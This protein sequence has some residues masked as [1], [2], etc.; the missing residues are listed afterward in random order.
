M[1]D[2]A[3]F[4][5]IG[6]TINNGTYRVDQ[7]LASGGF[8]NTYVVTHQHFQKQFVL[9]ELFLK[10]VNERD[11]VDTTVSV[12]NADNKE[13]F[14]QHRRKFLKEA[15]R[16]SDL[17]N[18]HI[19][20]VHDLFE[21]N[22]TAYYVMD[23]IKGQS[24]RDM[25]ARQ[26]GGLGNEQAWD[27]LM[28]MLEA[29]DEVHAK[30]IQHLDIK[31]GNIMC[32]DNGC[33][34]LIDFG[35]SKVIQDDGSM[36]TTS[37]ATA[38]TPG[39][40]PIEQVTQ[41][42]DSYGPWTDFYAL[43]ATLYHVLTGNKPPVS[44]EIVEQKLQAFHFSADADPRLCQL[45]VWMMQLSRTD[46]PQS[47]A[48]IRQWLNGGSQ[49]STKQVP[50]HEQ[51]LIQR[52]QAQNTPASVVSVAN[53]SHEPQHKKKWLWPVVVA[54][55]L[56]IIGV[57]GFFGYKAYQKSQIDY[58]TYNPDLVAAAEAGDAEALAALGDCYYRGYGV[59][60]DCKMAFELFQK[61]AEKGNAYGLYGLGSCYDS[62]LGIKRDTIK[63]KDYL[64]Q[65]GKLLVKYGG[66]N[67]PRILTALGDCYL[68]GYGVEKNEM[69][70][71]GLFRLAA[72]QGYARAQNGFGYCYEMGHGV[73]KDYTEAVKWYRLA[74]EQGYAWAQINLGYCYHEGEGVSKDY[75]EAVKW[76]RLAAEQG[77][78]L[79]QHNLGV[80]YDEGQGVP[81]DYN[82]AVKWYRLAAE[83]G[84]ALAQTN[85]GY[86]Y[87]MG[88]GVA[89]DMKEAVEWYQKAARQGSSLAQQ[90]LR[91]L[92]KSW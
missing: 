82:E 50:V 15:R 6:S 42:V 23:Y 69:K 13:L 29:L 39:Y 30:N 16:L 57:G 85:L 18:K 37:T 81:Q 40:A 44:D 12:S 92:G 32:D 72:E 90:N 63:A 71:V 1:D 84:D 87:D 19:V 60:I 89:K 66:S 47:V 35:A 46:R 67:D 58:T 59:K 7:Y 8:G 79:A 14:E 55:A 9:K 88:H 73:S 17:R 43:G 77:Y 21:D 70:A 86:C 26:G 68:Y 28:Q 76:Y 54:L 24:L 5:P 22:G 38:Y 75:T 4:L 2:S 78:A 45:I 25:I 56:C 62:G 91:N 49:S 10:G 41:K 36:M 61:A 52:Q 27:C 74:A 51:T 53:L 65:A 20:V 83:Q 48:D 34:S 33:L 11:A 64:T 31:P 80:C 3:N